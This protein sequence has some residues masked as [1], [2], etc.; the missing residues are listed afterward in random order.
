MRPP[1]DLY[2]VWV[3]PEPL[4]LSN[5]M[6]CNSRR[7]A[8][9]ATPFGIVQQPRNA[10]CAALRHGSRLKSTALCLDFRAGEYDH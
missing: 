3:S 10:R 2:F 6:Q 7:T 8:N 9:M 1:T 5:L 4:Y